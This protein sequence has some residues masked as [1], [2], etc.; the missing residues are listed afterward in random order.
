MTALL[1]IIIVHSSDRRRRN[2][3]RGAR[4]H[5]ARLP[6]PRTALASG[7]HR[8]AIV[9]QQSREY[10]TGAC[11]VEARKSSR[12]RRNERRY[13]PRSRKRIYSLRLF[14]LLCEP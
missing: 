7:N 9:R 4:S 10:S 13:G 14:L 11:A 12:R 8:L 6:E 5:L 3:V 1:N 2:D